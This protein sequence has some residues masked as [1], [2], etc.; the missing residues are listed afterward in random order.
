[1][2]TQTKQT[3]TQCKL[4]T[5]PKPK[6]IPILPTCKWE[7]GLQPMVVPIGVGLLCSCV[8]VVVN[9]I[10]ACKCFIVVVVAFGICTCVQC[11]F[12]IPK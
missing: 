4:K 12:L 11:E 7:D 2:K 5:H 3:M 9:V 10:V 1:M 8:I 6:R